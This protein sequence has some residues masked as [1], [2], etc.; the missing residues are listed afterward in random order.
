MVGW[1]TPTKNDAKDYSYSQGNHEK[2]C[3]KLP[4]EAKLAAWPTPKNSDHRSGMEE[5]SMDGGRSNLN[6]R[7]MAASW[8]TPLAKD[9]STA[10]SRAGEGSAALRV[11]ATLADSGRQPTGFPAETGRRAQLNP[12]HS[13]WLMGLPAEWLLACPPDRPR[14]KKRKTSSTGT[15]V[16]VHSGDS[17]TPSSHRSPSSSSAL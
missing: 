1:K 6:D 2:P 15:T 7:A 4:G 8:P 5:R 3:W 12:E 13:R 16:V 11:T 17:A 14:A 10:P 9:A